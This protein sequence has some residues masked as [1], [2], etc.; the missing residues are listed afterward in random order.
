MISGAAAERAVALAEVDAVPVPVED[1][2]H[3]DVT[4]VLDPLLEVIESSPKAALPRPRHGELGL[5]LAG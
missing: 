5:H 2:L 1:H 3:L 4:V